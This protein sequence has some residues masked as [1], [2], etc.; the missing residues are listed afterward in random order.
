MKKHP[1]ALNSDSLKAAVTK[2][3]KK[4]NKGRAKYGEFAKLSTKLPY[5]KP[6]LQEFAGSNWYF[7]P[8]S[9]EARSYGWWPMLTVIKGKL[10]RNDH[11]YSP[12]TTKHQY[13]LDRVLESLGIKPDLTISVRAAIGSGNLESV[14][15]ELLYH[16]AKETVRLRYARNKNP[17]LLP[18]LDSV[19]CIG[20]RYNKADR[21]AA[22]A[23]AESD[24]R[25]RLDRKRIERKHASI[26]INHDFLAEAPRL[27][28]VR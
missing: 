11:N 24:R 27:T 17:Y 9:L 14:K 12:A 4:I 19:R 5:Y 23:R 18:D 8:L 6:R 10:V 21:A 22:L 1:A 20:I 7:N 28:L 13:K 16:W 15:A 2:A 25:D 26:G 3:L